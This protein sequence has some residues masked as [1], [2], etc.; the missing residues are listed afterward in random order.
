[1][2]LLPRLHLADRYPVLRGLSA[3]FLLTENVPAAHHRSRNASGIS[4]PPLFIALYVPTY[5]LSAFWSGS[6]RTAIFAVCHSISA[7]DEIFQRTGGITLAPPGTST[8][9]FSSPTLLLY[10]LHFISSRDFHANLPPEPDPTRRTLAA[11]AEKQVD[12]LGGSAPR[13]RGT[14]GAL[15]AVDQRVP[16]RWIYLR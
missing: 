13:V 16:A 15:S 3:L 10:H 1:M 9:T 7:G 5:W 11:T 6:T 14:S 4:S 8:M 12:K 2:V